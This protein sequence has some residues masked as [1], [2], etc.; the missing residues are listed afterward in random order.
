M[1][2]NK[3]S[4]TDS[5]NRQDSAVYK[6]ILQKQC[7]PIGNFAQGLSNGRSCAVSNQCLSGVCSGMCEGKK[8]GSLCLRTSECDVGLGCTP[9]EQFPFTMRC[10]KLLEA[11]KKCLDTTD[12]AT[13]HICW[14]K[15]PADSAT[16]QYSC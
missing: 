14:P 2:A 8:E 10:R 1:E 11:D 15:N 9:E 16:K 3:N 6:K 7:E 13:D 12:C 5:P 4:L